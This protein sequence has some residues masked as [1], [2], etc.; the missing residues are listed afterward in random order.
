[1]APGAN[2]VVKLT[3]V[4]QNETVRF[5]YEPIDKQLVTIAV[6]GVTDGGQPLFQF[7]ETVTHGTQS[8]DIPIFTIPNY[9]K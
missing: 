4:T 9:M 5:E 6:K 8:K 7:T 2:A 1:M 3:N